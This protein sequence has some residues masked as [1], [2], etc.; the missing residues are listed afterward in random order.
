MLQQLV[1]KIRELRVFGSVIE[2][3][4]MQNQF[5]K[6]VIQLETMTNGKIVD[7]ADMRPVS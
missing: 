4:T 6:L 7:D 2:D 5:D 1:E 3:E